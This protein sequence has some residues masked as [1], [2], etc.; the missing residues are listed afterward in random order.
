MPQL[1]L[2][3]FLLLWKI[4]GETFIGKFLP[5]AVLPHIQLVINISYLKGSYK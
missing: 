2:T 3:D 1:P 5:I 4:R